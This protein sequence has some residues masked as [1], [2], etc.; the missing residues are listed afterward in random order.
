MI[1]EIAAAVTGGLLVGLL[2]GAGIACF[3][4]D[5]RFGEGHDDE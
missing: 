1:W 3:R 5:R 2:V 4:M